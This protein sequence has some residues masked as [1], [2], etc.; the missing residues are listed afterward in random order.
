MFGRQTSGSVVC[1]SC[2]Y[3]VGVSDD[4]C[5]NCGRRNPGLWGYA[6]AVRRLGSDLGFVPFV[7]GLSVVCYVASLLMSRGEIGMVGFNFL[8]PSGYANFIMGASGAVPIFLYDRWWT[9]LSAGFL[10]GSLIHILFNMYWVKQLAPAVSDLYGPGRMVI[11]YIVSSAVGFLFSSFAGAFLGW[12][13]IRLFHGAQVTVG[14][15]AAIFGFLGALVYYGRRSGSTAVYT[16]ALQYAVMMFVL[17][18]LMSSI[19]NWAHGGGFIGGYLVARVLDPLQ[20]E[21]VNHMATGL[22]LIV[23]SVLSIILSVVHGLYLS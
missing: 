7:I 4:K 10:H 9:I 18:L 3:L 20:P 16:Q 12:I 11:I 2:G 22:V 1:V 14:A 13:P 17:G 23:L 21:R 8:S 19:D 6:T 15:S 5:Y